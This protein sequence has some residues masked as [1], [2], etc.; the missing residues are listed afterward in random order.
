MMEKPFPQVVGEI[1]RAARRRRGMTLRAVMA[2]SDGRFKPS[3]LGGYERGERMISLARFCEL[4]ELCGVPPDRLLGEILD[5][6]RPRA[7]QQVVLELP[8][9]DLLNDDVLRPV[10]RFAR[11]VKRERGDPTREVLSLRAGDIQAI[12]LS[13]EIPTDHLASELD[14]VLAERSESSP[15]T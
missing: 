2:R 14:V 4:S 9:L 15:E 12:G 8:R 10:S 13:A 1:L 11:E 6:L 3:A 5:R 7:R